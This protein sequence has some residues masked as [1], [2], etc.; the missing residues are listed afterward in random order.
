MLRKPKL[1][2]D[3]PHWSPEDAQIV[4][5]ARKRVATVSTDRLLDHADEAGSG[6]AKGFDDF[7]KHQDLTSI[8]EIAEGLLVLWAITLELR[9]RSVQH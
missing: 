1:P 6:M 5:K 7:R 4:A 3:I 9:D 8:S 2:G